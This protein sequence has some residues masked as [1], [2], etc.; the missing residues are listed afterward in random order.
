MTAR[1]LAIAALLAAL[2]AAALAA[3]GA[4]RISPHGSPESGV[5]RVPGLPRGDCGHCHGAA[6]EPTG[7]R[8]D[9][10]GHAK[11]FAANDNTLCTGC[12]LRP[13]RS[14][15]GDLRYGE[16][17]HGRSP[18]AV[19]PGP[20]PPARSSGDAGKC[21]NCHDPHGVKDS[22][23]LVPGL[24][25]ARGVTHCLAC[26][27]GDPGPDVSSA[28]A[29]SFRHPLVA[30]PAGAAFLSATGATAGPEPVL[31][32]GDPT[33]SACHNP[34]VA[35]QDA[36]RPLLAGALRS[37]AGVARVRA[38]GGGSGGRLFALAPATET[39]RV[40]EFEVCYKCHSSAARRTTRGVDLA[41]A[42]DPANPSYHPV[43]A[44]GRNRAIER[45]A[46]ASGWSAE[47]LVTCSD[48]HGSDDETQRGPHGSANAYILR[49]RQPSGAGDQQV[50]ETDLC[51]GCHAFATY[52]ESKAAAAF[53]RYA[54]HGA[55]AARGISCWTCHDSHGSATLP[56][57]LAI[58]PAGLSAYA[59][60]ATGGTCTVA[61]HTRS[62][63][64]VSYRVS[65]GR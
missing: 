60:D 44:Q 61:C 63:A 39:T 53:S 28:F 8:S 51:F 59:Q 22:R 16:S 15:L 25:R 50:T 10:S 56:A 58:R 35:G 30:D 36:I 32:A 38:S 7:R 9:G 14:Y 29:K 33:C 6:R 40:R 54:G 2:P 41:A 11:L 27:R 20:V 43:E 31:A 5:R 57:L 65:Y 1:R 52:G 19:W 26:H 3:G 64:R 42:L 45:R 47:K 17:A 18:S 55:H 23:G 21:V 46:F 12:H 37:L 49:K 24:L 62:P 13:S 34:H 4:Y 48:C